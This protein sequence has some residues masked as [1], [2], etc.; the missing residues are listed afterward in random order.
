MY[1][2]SLFFLCFASKL[3]A[4][5]SKIR[6]VSLASRLILSTLKFQISF[7]SRIVYRYI[8]MVNLLVEMSLYQ[9]ESAFTCL[10]GSTKLPID[11]INGTAYCNI[12]IT[13]F[14]FQISIIILT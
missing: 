14:L 1:L 13:N 7:D 11:W 9:V 8:H 2:I 12:L 3:T 10:D 4:T 5:I 6:G